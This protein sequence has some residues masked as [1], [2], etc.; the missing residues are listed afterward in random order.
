MKSM[1]CWT[2][3]GDLKQDVVEEKSA[4]DAAQLLSLLDVPQGE[5]LAEV[6]GARLLQPP[7]VQTTLQLAPDDKMSPVF[8]DLMFLA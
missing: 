8:F 3:K 2:F 4:E 7:P 1:Q 6:V 5:S